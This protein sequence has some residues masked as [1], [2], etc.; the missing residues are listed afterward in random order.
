[1]NSSSVMEGTVLSS[2]PELL[3]G[4]VFVDANRNG[5]RNGEEAGL[6]DVVVSN[7]RDVVT[8]DDE[9]KYSIPAH[10]NSTIFI[11][12]PS[13]YQ[14]P[15]DSDN[16][17]QFHYNHLPEGSPDLDYG[18]IAPTGPLPSAVNF[19]VA[20]SDATAQ[21]EQ[22]C[23][24]AGDLQTYDLDEV[25]YAR[26]GAIADL[27]ARD[28]FAGCGVLF[29]G[30]VVGDDLD[31]FSEVRDLVQPLNG[32]AWFLPG[33][34][35]LD[36]DAPTAEH[37]F[38]TFRAQLAPAYYSYDVG[39]THI[40]ALNTVQ[41]PCLSE[42]GNAAELG[43]HCDDPEGDPKYN[44]R[45]GA[46]QL[47]WLEADLA[48]VPEDK[49]IVLAGHIGLVNFND[50]A[51]PIHQVDQV[52]EIHELIG[53]RPA[54]AVSG[55]SHTLENMQA[56]DSYAGWDELWGVDQLPFPH[57]TAGAISGDWYSGAL[58]PD[59][60]PVSIGKDGA[61]PGVTT[62]EI[63]GSTYAET[64]QA[65]GL[66]E[67]EQLN[68][69]INSPRYRTWLSEN[70]DAA[71]EAE[72]LADPNR[73]TRADLNGTTWLTTNFWIGSTGATVEVTL[74]GE[75]LG[76][77]T[78]TQRASGET[79]RSGAQYSDPAAVLQQLVNGGSP[80]LQ[81]SHLWRI[82]LPADLDTGTHVAE[83]TATD[84]NGNEF[85]DRILFTVGEE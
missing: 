31:L 14:V 30:D 11:T 29:L 60:F 41:Y 27:T 47:A 71:G 42:E 67:S 80:A 37:S 32:P 2:L 56:G 7:G 6:A 25:G 54:V 45:L 44:A 58:T 19:P 40:I 62:L 3:T 39:D 33:N 48:T 49:L 43:T 77:A 12:Q 64:F 26:D 1:M 55:H 68:L 15:L 46:D 8:T 72:P 13:G 35:D 74:D 9:G 78:R 18:G 57:L 36:F 73:I 52:A 50:Q 4:Q 82:E 81:S 51:S 69:G 24:M 76:S 63:D 65:S 21:P 61:R 84:R 16:V 10:D 83:V 34:H 70:E 17:P 20:E 22:N 59:G 66:P 38:D 53:D 23:V 5:T 28:D 75:R 79:L 85:T